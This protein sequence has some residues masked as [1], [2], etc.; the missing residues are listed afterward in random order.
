MSHNKRPGITLSLG[1]RTAALVLALWA[2]AMV[3]MT[4]GAAKLITSAA[5]GG[6]D[7]YFD[8]CC[9]TADFALTRLHDDPDAVESGSYEYALQRVVNVTGSIYLNWHGSY[10]PY[11]EILI[12]TNYAAALC[13]AG[14]NISAESRDCLNF[15]FNRGDASGTAVYRIDQGWRW[16]E[17]YLSG[18][19]SEEALQFLGFGY[20]EF[21]AR[22]DEENGVMTKLY[23]LE[24]RNGGAAHGSTSWTVIAGDCADA[25]EN[26]PDSAETL[27]CYNIMYS[28]GATDAASSARVLDYISANIPENGEPVSFDNYKLTELIRTARFD[29]CDPDTGEY[30]GAHYLVATISCSPLK[31]ALRAMTKVYIISF[32]IVALCIFAFIYNVR[33]HIAQPLCTI[34]EDWDAGYRRSRLYGWRQKYNELQLLADHYDAVAA[35]VS[36]ADAE[37]SR[38][39]KAVKFAEDA[40]RNRRQLTNAIAHE[41]KTPLAII[42]SYVEGLSEH[43]AD[44][45]RDRYLEVITQETE[46]M[47]ALVLDMLDLS[48]MEAGRTKLNKETF[49][50]S[51]L[52]RETAGRFE[53]SAADKGIKMTL[54][55]PGEY[56]VTA[57]KGRISQVMTNFLMN[58]LSHCPSGGCISA[59]VSQSGRCARFSVENS[60][61]KI[62]EEALSKVWDSFYRVRESGQ[63]SGLGLTISK[64]IIDLHGGACG[65]EN[66]STGVIFWFNI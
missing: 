32:L 8:H 45:K 27:L 58:A 62:P 22:C 36:N 60:G 21:R 61:E 38:M 64:S 66:T 13:D 12:R 55:A 56:P 16:S 52:A 50:L 20:T 33:S 53:K 41:L 59:K 31:T 51:A 7:D 63:G 29:V 40:E 25:P 42:H 5:L 39:K 49:S 65:V 14:G 28:P 44:D 35:A 15:S 9:T 23:L 3:C 34:N 47:D 10:A 4:L 18:K 43:I 37:V 17:G 48:R 57:D 30:D 11:S 54:D 19:T 24:G 1:L 6:M 26:I 46:R 2:A